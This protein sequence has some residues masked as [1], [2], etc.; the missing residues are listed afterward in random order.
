MS[1]RLCPLIVAAALACTA[2]EPGPSPELARVARR[3]L[4][5][6]P[7]ELLPQSTPIEPY[8]PLHHKPFTGAVGDV[9]G[10]GQPDVVAL[11]HGDDASAL[12][13]LTGAPDGTFLEGQPTAAPGHGL[14]LGDL[15]RDGDL[16]ALLLDASGAPKYRVAVN[17]GAGS[18]TI[19]RAHAI[20]GRFGG[21]LRGAA[22][23]DLDGDGRLDAA[24]PLW[25]S[26][27]LLRG[28]GAGGFT[29]GERLAVGRDPFAVEL[30]DL[31]GDGVLDLATISGAGPA[32]GRDEYESGGASAWIFRGQAGLRFAAPVRVEIS[33]ARALALTDL[34]GDGAL[35]LAVHG[36]AGLT[37]LHDPLGARRRERVELASD[38]PLVSADL[39]GD[40]RP[41]LI[42]SSF[43][44][45]RVHLLTSDPARPRRSIEAGSFAVGL[46]VEHVQKDSLRPALIVLNAGPPG[47]PYGA[48][49]PSVEVLLPEQLDPS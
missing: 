24:V 29:P 12:V 1:R 20:P 3:P 37:L 19:G 21:E 48:P 25:D 16:D 49:A 40:A 39:I 7:P 38:G 32:R 33:G 11:C 13:V 28:D 27:R 34:N 23:R 26:V 47:P 31:D 43:M 18:W 10:D 15:D 46:F 36:A 41:E 9:T 45:G 44:Q 5:A 22:L 6:E 30:G 35:E 14:A 17:D 8:T 42:T 4:P 2:H